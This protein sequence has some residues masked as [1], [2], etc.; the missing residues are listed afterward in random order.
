MNYLKRKIGL[1]IMAGVLATPPA[2]SA[3]GWSVVDIGGDYHWYNTDSED[4]NDSAGYRYKSWSTSGLWGLYTATHTVLIGREGVNYPDYGTANGKLDG[5]YKMEIDHCN[6]TDTAS[7]N[8]EVDIAVE[9]NGAMNLDNGGIGGF[10]PLGDA[11]CFGEAY[12]VLTGMGDA[13]AHVK[14][15]ITAEEGDG[16]ASVETP[17]VGIPVP[18]DITEDSFTFHGD[19]DKDTQVWSSS[20]TK[21]DAVKGNHIRIRGFVDTSAYCFDGATSATI[22]CKTL[23]ETMELTKN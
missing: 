19:G 15:T 13:L 5:W 7:Y 8:W 2:N 16:E 1:A 10:S 20:G 23:I 6:A 17:Y 9:M 4:V 11:K 18:I 22:T 12:I 3:F 21:T 14:G